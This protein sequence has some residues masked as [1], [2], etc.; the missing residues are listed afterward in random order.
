MK[1]AAF[2]SR[3]MLDL[4]HPMHRLYK[5]NHSSKEVELLKRNERW[6]CAHCNKNQADPAPR[7]SNLL[8]LFLE[9][10]VY[11]ISDHDS[12]VS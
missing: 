8:V 1:H 12:H 7:R 6:S 9:M 11:S 3:G 10:T 4:N 5:I 2:S